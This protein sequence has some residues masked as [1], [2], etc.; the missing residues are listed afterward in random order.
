MEKLLKICIFK[1][2]PIFAGN[3]IF[4]IIKIA[5]F[6]D[7]IT[8]YTWRSLVNGIFAM[9]KGHCTPR[10]IGHNRIDAVAA[11]QKG[12]APLLDEVK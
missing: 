4:V 10:F 7:A 1:K 2:M 12:L 11:C 8:P 3:K 9:T 6:P 5:M